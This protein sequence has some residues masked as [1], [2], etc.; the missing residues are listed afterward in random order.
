[1]PGKRASPVLRGAGRS[2]A[3]RLPDPTPVVSRSCGTR[4]P[5]WV[6]NTP[7]VSGAL[8]VREAD[9]PAGTGWPK[10]RRPA[11]ERQQE[12]G[13]IVVGSSADLLG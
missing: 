10:K 5:R 8:T 1:M 6:R 4:Q 2:N 12:T 7:C 3:S 13:E 11:A 9:H